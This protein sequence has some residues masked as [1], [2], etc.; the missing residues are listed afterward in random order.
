MQQ[1]IYH[2]P[3]HHHSRQLTFL[4]YPLA[5]VA[6]VEYMHNVQELHCVPSRAICVTSRSSKEEMFVRALVFGNWVNITTT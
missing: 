1:I 4:D 6:T 5:Q 3:H 2:F